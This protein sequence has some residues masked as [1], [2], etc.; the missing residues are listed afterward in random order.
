MGWIYGYGKVDGK[1]SLC[2]VVIPEDGRKRIWGHRISWM[3]LL[4]HPIM[5]IMD[6][7]EQ[8][9]SFNGAFNILKLEKSMKKYFGKIVKGL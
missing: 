4:K 9:K 1:I 5:V 8:K 7:L 3:E 6:V 2:E